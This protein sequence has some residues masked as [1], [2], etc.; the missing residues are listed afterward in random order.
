M[1]HIR[2]VEAD[3]AEAVEEHL[4]GDDP[5]KPGTDDR[6]RITVTARCIAAAV[7]G[8]MEVW[9]LGEDR[10]LPELDAAVPHGAGDAAEGNRRRRLEPKFRHY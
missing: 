3:F 7:F 1:R 8:A 2:Q 10:S 6:M 5:P 4:G 9:M